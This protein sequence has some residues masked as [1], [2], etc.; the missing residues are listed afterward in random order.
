MFLNN[1]PWAIGLLIND[2]M[3]KRADVI[4]M[5]TVSSK[6]TSRMVSGEVNVDDV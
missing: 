2:F 5:K 4:I 1:I 3:N 6:N